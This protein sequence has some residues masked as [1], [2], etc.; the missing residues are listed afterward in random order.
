M[1]TVLL[2]DDDAA[3]RRLVHITLGGGAHY[4]VVHAQDGPTGVRLARD[5]RVD[6]AVVDLSMPGVDGFTVCQ[7]LKALPSEARPC[8]LMLTAHGSTTNRTKARM[9]GAD[10]FMAKPFSPSSLLD[11]I[12]RLLRGPRPAATDRPAGRIPVGGRR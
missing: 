7:L 10:E 4:Q 3:L 6:L 12:E 2:V 8:V 9:V 11:A 5:Q 1:K